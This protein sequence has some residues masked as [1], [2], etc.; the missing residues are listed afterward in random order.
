MFSTQWYTMSVK[1]DALALHLRQ[2]SAANIHVGN[3]T[4][5]KSFFYS[6]FSANQKQ[7]HQLSSSRMRSGSVYEYSDSRFLVFTTHLVSM[8][9]IRTLSRSFYKVRYTDY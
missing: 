8:S 9:K 5:E 1:Y 3:R 4:C 7:L 6:R 2:I